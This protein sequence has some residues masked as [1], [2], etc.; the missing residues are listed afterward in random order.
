[1]GFL[2]SMFKDR[3]AEGWMKSLGKQ[4]EVEPHLWQYYDKLYDLSLFLKTHPGGE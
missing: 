1:M 3:S 2:T 4:N